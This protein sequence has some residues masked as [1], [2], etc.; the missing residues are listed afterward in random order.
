M[1]SLE[2]SP[3]GQTSAAL[4]RNQ[5]IALLQAALNA[6]QARFARQAAA[7]WLQIYSG[8][9]H[10]QLLSA[11][12]ILQDENAAA[13]VQDAL[14]MLE[15]LCLKDPEFAEAHSLLFHA[16]RVTD[17]PKLGI[18][19]GNYLALTGKTL[20]VPNAGNMNGH[21]V[22]EQSV[23]EQDVHEIRIQEWGQALWEAR[24]YIHQEDFARADGRL[25]QAFGEELR[26]H[27]E[28]MKGLAPLV[29][30]TQIENTYFQGLKQADGDRVALRSLAELYSQQWQD[31]L[32]FVLIYA[33]SLMD[34]GESDRAVALL[35]QAAAQDIGGQVAARLWGAQHPYRSLWYDAVSAQLDIAVPASVA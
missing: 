15:T 3:K 23:H 4:N 32:P 29:A 18:A 21:P 8:D 10:V 19:R 20:T 27:T 9:L 11:Q 22:Q 7:Q 1:P 30:L 17:S 24:Q 14:T 16:Y 33:D 5:F 26:T 35:H 6:R 28:E 34:G 12:A 25:R 2:N 31:C 13:L